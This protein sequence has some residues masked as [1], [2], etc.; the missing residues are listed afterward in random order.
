MQVPLRVMKRYLLFFA[1]LVVLLWSAIP[2]SL[3]G[4]QYSRIVDVSR[5]P[6]AEKEVDYLLSR[7]SL[8]EQIGQLIIP[9]I[10]PASTE[11]A[12]KKA[13]AEIAASYAGGILYQKGEAYDQWVMNR[14]LQKQVAVP[15]L[16]TADAEWGLAMRL[17]NTIRYPRNMALANVSEETL[18]RE[19]GVS[20]ARQCKVI[21][22][23]VNF[24]PVLDVNNN[25]RNPVIG[26]RSFG[27]DKEAVIR[28]GL[29]YAE[30]LEQ[31]GVLSVAK[32]F[33]GHGDTSVDSHHALP[34]IKGSIKALE[35]L[36]LKP[37][38]A[39]FNR[40]MGGVM[41]GH[42][43]VPSM[44]NS[45][46][47]ASMSRK[48]TTTLLQEKMKFRGL[49]F[50]DGMQM[51]GMQ[52]RGGHSISVRAFLAG[53]DLL[54]GP[55]NPATTHK[56]LLQAVASGV[57]DKNEVKARCRKILIYKWFLMGGSLNPI[58]MPALTQKEFYARL[59]TEEAR[60]LANELWWQSIRIERGEKSLLPLNRKDK[61][62]S[63][64]VVDI[65][66]STP[67]KAF[68][69]ALRKIGI[70]IAKHLQ[71][72]SKGALQEQ[73]KHLD[74][75]A[76]CDIVFVN[77]TAGRGIPY[78]S[79][80]AQIAA[81]TQVIFTLFSSPYALP[82]W[83]STL[84]QAKGVACAYEANDEAQRAVVGR[85]FYIDPNDMG[86]VQVPSGE[87]HKADIKRFSQENH[88]TDITAKLTAPNFV[89]LE[90][91]VQQA[92]ADK[93]FP[94]C[95]IVI[96]HKGETVYNNA[97]G[98]TEGGSNSP[99]VNT[100]T[101][102]DM[103]SI[104][105]AAATTPI[106]M[107]LVSQ[108]VL[109]L[110]NRVDKYIPEV[111]NT[112]VARITLRELLLH[113][114]GLIPTIN[115]YI[116]LLNPD[117]FQGFP[118]FSYRYK[119][120]WTKIAQNTWI[121][122]SIEFDKSKVTDRESENFSI[123]FGSHLYL[124]NSFKE[125]MLS[126]IGETPLKSKNT[127]RYSD[128]GFILIGVMAERATGKSLEELAQEL[129][130]TPMGL[131]TMGYLPTKK[132]AVERIAPTQEHCFL[133]GKVWGTVDDETAACRGG[134]AGNAG[135][136]GTATELAEVA[137]MILDNGVYHQQQIIPSTVVRLFRSTRGVGGR[138]SLGFEIGKPGVNIP[139]AASNQ[140]FGHSG[141]T[142]CIV[143]IDPVNDLVFVFLSNRTY[144]T[145]LNT[146]LI[147][148]KTR[149]SLLE[150]TYDA[151]GIVS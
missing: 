53:N 65:Y 113:Q 142:G 128:V 41:I 95:Q 31:E 147:S 82:L 110:S 37:F 10:Y 129:I 43:N 4:Q 58:D 80:I 16:I 68:K 19:W 47:P 76:K 99:R 14:A 70:P 78:S 120:G 102:Y 23:H 3:W 85:Y 44:D 64:G 138:R 119:S 146:K 150:S 101:I 17:S 116:D 130:Y 143:W 135:L 51:K 141:F 35:N 66:T 79:F 28:C 26:T 54:L 148:Q 100:N 62:L 137:Q 109:A 144:P 123:P 12:I 114:S 134:V 25:P 127:Y 18:L 111:K 140:T 92:I 2:A 55:I 33:P 72:S 89:S 112:P 74:D 22:I 21:G 115:F 15:L 145:R 151:L 104:T 118:L 105:K 121:N 38:A 88:K 75:L 61:S 57:I 11:V 84:S 24:A 98:S 29:A 59:N 48:I 42:L 124:S 108:G 131:Q 40:G 94:G 126:K 36:E 9:V 106:A 50:T 34:T 97:F 81:R 107:Q 45:G 71:L 69:E 39:Y 60:T 46:T 30:G 117:S 73:H 90:R 8:E 139:E 149:L 87:N 83:Q 6:Q 20:M 67:P 96:H 86:I 27:E 13:K 125:E 93:V 32:H 1:F 5:L 132:F 49:I 77:C 52:Q 122:P 136:F 7:M 63:Y 103:A 56:E 91:I 133:R